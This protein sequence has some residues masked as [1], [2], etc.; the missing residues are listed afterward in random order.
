MGFP[1]DSNIGVPSGVTLTP[2]GSI[3]ID[4]AGGVVT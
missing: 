4:T 1:D 3:T 2:S